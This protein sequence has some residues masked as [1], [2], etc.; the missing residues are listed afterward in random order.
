FLGG[1][2]VFFALAPEKALLG[3]INSELINAYKQ[4]RNRTSD[5]IQRLE[6]LRISKRVFYNLRATRPSQAVDRAVRFLYLNRTAF[7]GIYRVNQAGDFNVP[8]GCKPGTVLCD[9]NVINTAARRLKLAKIIP[10]D[11]EDTIA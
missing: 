3:D 8:F 2:A 6:Q 1:G 11:F 9:P 4:V 7:N 5:V 10:A